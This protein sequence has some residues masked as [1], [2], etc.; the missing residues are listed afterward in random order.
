MTFCLRKLPPPIV[1]TRGG[2]ID[3][4]YEGGKTR[5]SAQAT[6]LLNTVPLEVKLVLH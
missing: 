5:V 4:A 2:L 1:R 6:F 3:G